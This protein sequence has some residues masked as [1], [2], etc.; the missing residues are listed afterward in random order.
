MGSKK[1]IYVGN[2]C[3]QPLFDQL[4]ARGAPVTQAAENLETALLTGLCQQ[5]SDL[6]II[7]FIPECEGVEYTPTEIQGHGVDYIYV[8][9]K[10]IKGILKAMSAFGKMIRAERPGFDVLTYAVNPM[11]AIPLFFLRPFKKITCTTLCTELPQY[12]RWKASRKVRIKHWIQQKLNRQF[13]KYIL[14]TE[15]MAQAIPTKKKPYMVM[16]GICRDD[17]HGEPTAEKR[18]ALMYAG[19]LTEDNG[20]E[21]LTEAFEKS[22]LEEFWVC[23]CGPLDA[24]IRQKAE[25]NPRIRFFGELPV[26][27]VQELERRALILANIRDPENPLTW[28]SFP[29][30]VLEYMSCGTVVI[31]T[32]LRGIPEEYYNYIESVM[33]YSV[34][35]VLKAIEKTTSKSSTEYQEIIGSQNIFLLKRK[36]SLPQTERVL[37]FLRQ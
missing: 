32:V 16:E 2:F 28:Y 12:R 24:Y 7:S 5:V 23:G 25:S 29:S 19:G 22:D 10:S 34:D 33:N 15:E 3:N 35:A 37:D 17:I 30:K 21:L 8:N 26:V 31:S 4:I 36:S 18:R 6:R 27:K 14:L 20:L 11:S 13:D 1:L 9:K